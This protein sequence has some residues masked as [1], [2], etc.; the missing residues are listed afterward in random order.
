MV[1]NDVRT[2][3]H[4]LLRSNVEVK[5]CDVRVLTQ[6]RRSVKPKTGG[7]QKITWLAVSDS[8]IVGLVFGCC[9]CDRLNGSRVFPVGVGKDGGNVR[10]R[11]GD[12]T[13]G[14]VRKF[15]QP[16]TQTR[17]RYRPGSRGLCTG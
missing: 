4:G 3:E 1:I 2:E 16:L 13:T 14:S 11:Q 8:E 7:I 6:R 15:H 9:C 12:E 10:R 17:Q 5:P